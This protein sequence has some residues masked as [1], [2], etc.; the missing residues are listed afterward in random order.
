[1]WQRVASQYA[2]R[3]SLRRGLPANWIP[4]L[5]S[6]LAPRVHRPQLRC[7]PC[8]TCN[9]RQRVLIRNLCC[10]PLPR[11]TVTTTVAAEADFADGCT[12]RWWNDC[13]ERASCAKHSNDACVRGTQTPAICTTER[14]VDALVDPHA[15]LHTGF[16]GLPKAHRNV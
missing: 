13:A 6:P 5:Q 1:M 11:S 2:R 9:Q 7:R 12:S 15:S 16:G 10:W 3:Q 14:G 8:Q 4:R